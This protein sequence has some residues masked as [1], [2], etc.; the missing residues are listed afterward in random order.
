MELGQPYNLQ[1]RIDGYYINSVLKMPTDNSLEN[2]YLYL[3]KN[4]EKK[5]IGPQIRLIFF[6][7]HI[8]LKIITN[9]IGL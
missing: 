6:A 7:K 5:F 8:F 3:V 2:V 1:Y 4:F 9:R